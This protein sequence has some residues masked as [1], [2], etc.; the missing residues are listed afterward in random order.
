[1][2][3]C[4]NNCNI[5]ENRFYMS[6]PRIHQRKIFY[7]PC[8]YFEWNAYFLLFI[9]KTSKNSASCKLTRDPFSTKQWFHIFKVSGNIKNLF[10]IEY[11]KIGFKRILVSKYL[12]T[13][14][15]FVTIFNRLTHIPM[16]IFYFLVSLGP[17]S[18]KEGSCYFLLS[19]APVSIIFHILTF[20]Q[21]I[22]V[23][24]YIRR[25]PF[26]FVVDVCD[27]LSNVFTWHQATCIA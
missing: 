11:F 13:C 6:V 4:V 22:D 20:T 3:Y 23:F 17:F 10:F 5:K 27:V 24:P 21:F 1:M 25:K 9:T 19:P 16:K 15:G 8:P 14:L 18:S 26:L 2:F 7:Q 12:L